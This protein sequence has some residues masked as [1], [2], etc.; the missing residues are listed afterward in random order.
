MFELKDEEKNSQ[1]K[2][3]A[4]FPNCASDDDVDVDEVGKEQS[5]VRLLLDCAFPLVWR[6]I[7]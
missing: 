4:S 3:L 1:S 2:F 6:G 7:C 5:H